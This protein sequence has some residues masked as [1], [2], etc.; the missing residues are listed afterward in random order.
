MHDV[1]LESTDF[2]L[3]ISSYHIYVGFLF[4]AAFVEIN[5]T[6]KETKV[7]EE[8]RGEKKPGEEVEVTLPIALW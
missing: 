4:C 1:V 8:A 3:I 6:Q 5:K 7:E 2:I